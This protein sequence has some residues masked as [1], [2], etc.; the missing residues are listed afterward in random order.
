MPADNVIAQPP[1]AHKAM[2]TAPTEPP[3]ALPEPPKPLRLRG[4]IGACCAIIDACLCCCAL[5]ECCCCG[6][7]ELC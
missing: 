3:A 1:A 5:E 7:A 6:L 2:T 4:G